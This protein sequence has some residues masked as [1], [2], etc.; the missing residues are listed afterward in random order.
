[1][2]ITT[3]KGYAVALVCQCFFQL[4]ITQKGSVKFFWQFENIRPHR[5]RGKQTGYILELSHIRIPDIKTT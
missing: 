4:R 1:M 5:K 3:E 2:I